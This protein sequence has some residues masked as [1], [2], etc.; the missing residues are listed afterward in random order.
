MDFWASLEHKIYYKYRREIPAEL[1]DGLREAAETAFTLD[2]TMERLHQEVRG[3]DALAAGGAAEAR[4]TTTTSR[5]RTS[6]SRC[7]GWATAG[8]GRGGTDPDETGPGTAGR[9]DESNR[10]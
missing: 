8:P 7:A 6:S 1:L 9:P 2:T 5:P 3:L 10:P 4:A